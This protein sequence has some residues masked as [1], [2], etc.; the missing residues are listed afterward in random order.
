MVSDTVY[1]SLFERNALPDIYNGMMY[2]R[3]STKAQRF[4]DIAGNIVA[5]WES[6]KEQLLIACHD[7]YPSTDVVF[8]LA[9]R[10]MDP[11]CSGLIDYEWF[12]FLHHKPAI[13]GLNKVKDQNNYLFPNKVGDAVYLGH[14]RV[15]RVWHY[16]DKEINVRSF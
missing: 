12:K 11:D 2:F 10:I 15:S 1:R 6:V 3:K 4:F 13:N 8:A 14:K 16:F 7:K 5:N 9:Y